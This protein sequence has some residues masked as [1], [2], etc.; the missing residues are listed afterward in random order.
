MSY[1]TS[2]VDLNAL[3]LPVCRAGDVLARLDECVARSPIRQGFAE[4]QDFADAVASMWTDGQL[5]HVED[6]VLH[7][8][9]KDARAP[10][11]E[12]I[13]A[14][15][16]L[17]SRR[18]ITDHPADWAL[19]NAGLSRLRGRETDL[20][21]KPSGQNVPLPLSEPAETPDDDDEADNE[22]A[23]IDAIIAR[24]NALIDDVLDEK[25]AISPA[26]ERDP[27]IY[28]ADWDEDERLEEW[29]SVFGATEGLPPVLRAA[30]LLDAWN[31]LQV[32]QHRPE[33]GRQLVC[34]FLR[35][36]GI[37]A[38]HLLA[39]NTGLKTVRIEKRRAPDRLTRVLAILEGMEAAGSFGLKE[40]DRLMISKAHLD[41]RIASK[42]GHSRLPQ[43]VELV[44]SRPVVSANLIAAE[45]EMTSQGALLL[46]KQ[47]G[48][49]EMTGR[50]RYRAWGIL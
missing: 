22:F 42:R 39:L 46:T 14:H 6:L 30:M 38:S 36:Q 41:R 12:L 32:L 37:V 3:L 44:I 5:V 2:R 34:A 9:R 43:L 31:E 27:V 35:G 21:I 48:L 19:N 26:P 7:D 49:R 10:T 28:D 15:S 13:V 50:G 47:L 16:I 18:Q 24:S 17:R 45:L 11:H 23:E 8:A 20:T 4:R 25:P 33:L 40:H 1:D 29:R